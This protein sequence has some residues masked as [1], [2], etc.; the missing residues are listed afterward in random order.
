[1]EGY[2]GTSRKH[3]ISCSESRCENGLMI[4]GGYLHDSGFD[5]EGKERPVPDIDALRVDC[6]TTIPDVP[7]RSPRRG[8][9]EDRGKDGVA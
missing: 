5:L 8:E 7:G 9:L 4:Q 1:M 3:N 2:Q 6:Y